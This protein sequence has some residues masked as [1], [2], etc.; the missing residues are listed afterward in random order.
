MQKNEQEQET[1]V[2]SK[3]AKASILTAN[4]RELSVVPDAPIVFRGNYAEVLSDVESVIG[5]Y[6][7][8]KIKDSNF[9]EAELA[10]KTCQSLR[11][12]ITNRMNEWKA[13]YITLP[14]DVEKAKFE[15][16]L[17]AVKEV[18]DSLD[19]QF[20]VFDEEK[21]AALQVAI[22]SYIAEAAVEF[23]FDHENEKDAAYLERIE[24]KKKFF[25]K[26]QDERDTRLDIFE[27]MRI[28]SDERAEAVRSENLVRSLC[29][30]DE[31]LDVEMYV[32]NLNYQSPSAVIQSIMDAKERLKTIVVG[33]T[34][35]KVLAGLGVGKGKGKKDEIK[36]MRIEITYMASSGE[37]ISAFFKAN[38]DIQ[39]RSIK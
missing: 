2:L 8:L 5:K 9:D 26:T 17:S 31:R 38:P 16:V 33:S 7:N 14:S 39:V 19:K 13:Q 28:L 20:D 11:T 35:E 23:H 36:T 1:K 15:R 27:Q 24:V 10:K 32:E 25:N 3:T 4:V 21:R 12:T 34:N 30:D 29:A 6:R 18:E 22:D 37:K